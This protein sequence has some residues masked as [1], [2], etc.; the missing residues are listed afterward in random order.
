MLHI[1]IGKVGWSRRWRRPRPRTTPIYVDSKYEMKAEGICSSSVIFSKA[2]TTWCIGENARAQY[3]LFFNWKSLS[4]L[5]RI[6]NPSSQVFLSHDFPRWN[7]QPWTSIAGDTILICFCNPGLKS[8][9]KDLGFCFGQ[10]FPLL[11][12]LPS[13]DLLFQ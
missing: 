7:K 2:V 5:Y 1:S 8:D 13:V 10:N 3:D 9:K 6:S 4:V 12:L 11:S